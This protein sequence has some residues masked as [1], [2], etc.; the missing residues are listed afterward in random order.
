MEVLEPGD[1]AELDRAPAGETPAGGERIDE[2]AGEESPPD[3]STR[4]AFW[5]F[6]AFSAFAWWKLIFDFGQER[7]FL[8]DDWVFLAEWTAGDAFEP[9]GAHLTTL[10]LLVFRGLFNLFGLRF[11]PYL[12]VLVTAHV[13]V[14]SLLRVVMRRSGVRPWLA[15]AAA[16]VL[17]FF[18]S[19][20][21]NIQWVFQIGFVAAVLFG[22]AQMVLSNHGGPIGRRDVLALAAGV[23]AIL[24]T[25]VGPIMVIAVG[26]A[27]LLRRGWRPA[28]F[29]T[30]PLAAAWLI[31]Y[32]VKDPRSDAIGDPPTIEIVR[33]VREGVVGTVDGI[34]QHAP[35]A[36][37]L[38]VVMVVGLVLLAVDSSFAEFRVR[39]A[40]PLGLLV[41][42]PAFFALTSRE[43][44]FFGS[45]LA[46]SGRY[47]YLGA[48]LSLPALALAS[49]A[50]ARRM[51]Y[52]TPILVVL[53]LAGI[54]GNYDMFG[55]GPSWGP[56]FFEGQ[57]RV[58]LALP[59]VAEAEDAPG[60]IRP[61]PNGF[62]GS[63]LTVEFLR[64]AA[65]DGRVP[66]PSEI[67]PALRNEIVLRLSLAHAREPWVGGDCVT[68]SDPLDLQLVEGDR[69]QILTPIKAVLLEDGVPQ[70]DGVGYNVGDGLFDIYLPEDGVGALEVT[71]P[72]LDVQVQVAWGQTEFTICR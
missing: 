10:P 4:A 21:E 45:E 13:G 1:V 12:T 49:E 18:G 53:I 5:A 29:Q 25:G 47:L 58:V 65:D 60:W 9:F 68:R 59:Y 38:A 17:L 69:L 70:P 40:M 27:T 36:I 37:A 24:S 8:R 48:V 67:D 22:L 61:E 39:A 35:V 52:A 43:R 64:E 7:W 55:H 71:A 31:W 11:T 33:W 54:P 51:R 14:A 30:V 62:N 56:A 19:G 23:A 72:Q 66:R 15:T 32:V 46:R 16:A 2:R 28:A 26:S 41:C 20:E 3:L 63:G 34:G 50:I 42:W 44:W 57:R 6:V